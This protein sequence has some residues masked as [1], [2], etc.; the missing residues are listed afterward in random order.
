MYIYICI[1]TL[2]TGTR[3]PF[4]VSLRQRISKKIKL[5]SSAKLGDQST[6]GICLSLI[7]QLWDYRYIL[8]HL[9]LYGGVK[10]SYSSICD[11]NSIDWLNYL[12]SQAWLF[13]PAKHC[14]FPRWGW[15]NMLV[16]QGHIHRQKL[17]WALP[18]WP[19]PVP[20]SHKFWTY[21]FILQ[22]KTC[23]TVYS[24]CDSSVTCIILCDFHHFHSYSHRYEHFF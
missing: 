6:T 5:N 2:H 18:L 1:C 10:L 15:T 19:T 24:V 13:S 21:V 9:A 8:P 20:D 4:L 11:K 16:T 7:L 23:K 12:P 22:P 3:S 17:H 14:C